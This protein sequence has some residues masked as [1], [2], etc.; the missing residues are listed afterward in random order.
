M[1]DKLRCTAT[2]SLR[3]TNTR[4]IHDEQLKEAG[5]TSWQLFG[6]Q[7]MTTATGNVETVRDACKVP[8]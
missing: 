3:V 8:K 5:Q 7:E 6:T 2:S 1:L 4:R